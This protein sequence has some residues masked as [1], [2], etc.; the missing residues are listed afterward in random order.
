M[1]KIAHTSPIATTKKGLENCSSPLKY[2]IIKNTT[3][4]PNVPIKKLTTIRVNI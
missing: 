2:V 3:S 1:D 4:E